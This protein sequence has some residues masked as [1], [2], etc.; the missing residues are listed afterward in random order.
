V[1]E[2]MSIRQV[3]SAGFVA[4]ILSILLGAVLNYRSLEVVQR[5]VSDIS[6]DA[7]PLIYLVQEILLEAEKLGVDI[8]FFMASRET[9]W[10]QSYRDGKAR[11]L[12]AMQ[13]LQRYQTVARQPDLAALAGRMQTALEDL[14]RFEPRIEQFVADPQSARPALSFATREISPLSDR[15]LRQLGE[16]RTAALDLQ[17]DPQ[18]RLGDGFRIY[19]T[20]EA[21]RYGW[22]NLITNIRGYLTFREDALLHNVEIWLEQSQRLAATLASLRPAMQLEQ[23]EPFEQMSQ[24][25]ERFPPMLEQLRQLHSRENLDIRMLREEIA[26]LIEDLQSFGLGL[27]VALNLSVLGSAELVS[28]QAREALFTLATVLLSSLALGLLAMRLSSVK[29][30]QIVS[31][32]SAALQPMAAGDLRQ[33]IDAPGGELRHIGDM[34]NQMAA[35]LGDLVRELAQASG[36][37]DS[38]AL[39]TSK[40]AHHTHQKSLSQSAITERMTDAIEVLVGLI[41]KIHGSTRQAVDQTREVESLMERG[42][43]T[44]GSSISAMERLARRVDQSARVVEQVNA[45]THRI[46][47][48]T[49]VI[50]EI[51]EQTNLLAL[52]A[53]IEAAR[54]GE[55]GRGFAVVADEVRTLSKRTSDATQEITEEVRNIQ[56]GAMGV[57]KRMQQISE[58]SGQLVQ[59]S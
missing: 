49:G 26:P 27:T 43:V 11:L 56:E 24:E 34:V 8:G 25:L 46:A 54:A 35:G 22:I 2:V 7:I 30:T 53:A 36:Q 52:N 33:R 44:I 41:E 16:M 20:I 14:M 29:V 21:M 51:A 55:Q 17:D 28:T 58:Q 31:R 23:E 40:A 1:I 47:T 6:G 50:R 13:R 42:R 37:L 3:V 15:V 39:E 18:E 38:V 12:A 19:Q 32:L 57:Q 48:V 10:W 45:A 5:G 4:V 59:D 9:S